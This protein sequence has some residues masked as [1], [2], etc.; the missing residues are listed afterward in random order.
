MSVEEI[1]SRQETWEK[2]VV[3]RDIKKMPELKREFKTRS[4]ITVKRLY[5]AADIAGLEYLRDLGFPGGYPY[6]RGIHSTMYR[7]KIWTMRQ[8]VGVGLPSETNKR[9]RFVINQGQTGLSND[10]DLPTLIGYDPDHPM[11][12]GEVCRVGLSITCL[13]DMEDLFQDIPIDEISTSFNINS[14]APFI[15]AAYMG[16]AKK[17]GIPLSRLRG[18]IQN[19]PLKEYP[20][21]NTYLLPPRAAFKIACD[22]IEYSIRNLPQWNPIS[23]SEYQFKDTG[24][25]TS[26]GLAFAFAN[27]L[28]YVDEL[29]RRGIDIDDLGPRLS[30]LFGVD[31]DFFEEIAKFRA[32]RKI[33]ATLLREKYGAEKPESL[34]LRVHTQTLGSTLTAQQP[35]VNLIRGTLQALAAVLGGAQS[36]A[37][38]CRDEALSIPSEESQKLSLRVQQVIALESGVTNTVDPLG[39]S[40]FVEYLTKKVEEEVMNWMGRIDENGGVIACVESGWME[41]MVAD[42]AYDYQKQVMSGERLKIGLNQFKEPEEKTPF[43]IFRVNPAVEEQ[44]IRFIERVRCERDAQAATSALRGLRRAAETGEN[45]VPLIIEA[46]TKQA[47]LG[48]VMGTLAEVHGIFRKPIIV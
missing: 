47:T 27:G 5:T 24:T 6:T 46:V 44:R 21:Q 4:G 10:F 36:L 12:R 33:W 29:V 20:T 32:A 42:S 30:F 48:E 19:D 15:M 26:M 16:L 22:L 38:S 13:Q 14:S 34:R 37:V 2:N 1:Q 25:D 40:Y 28:A 7:G 43:E 39:G 31:D 8:V 3:Q 23:I 35:D 18:T 9:H 45:V 11:S 17:R 41:K